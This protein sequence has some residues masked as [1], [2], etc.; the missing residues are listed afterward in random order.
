MCSYQAHRSRIASSA[1]ACPERFWGKWAPSADLC[2]EDKS[3]A[4][5]SGKGYVTE[6]E[7]CEEDDPVNA[8]DVLVLDDSQARAEYNVLWSNF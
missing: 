3:T 6:Q 8:G 5:V 7:S 4:V 1:R 2:R